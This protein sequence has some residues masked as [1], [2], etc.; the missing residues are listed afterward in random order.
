MKK[1]LVALLTV[2]AL[3]GAVGAVLVAYPNSAAAFPPDPMVGLV[4]EQHSPS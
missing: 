3:S 1:F 4:N 2:I